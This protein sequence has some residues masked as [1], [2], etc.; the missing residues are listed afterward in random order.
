MNPFSRFLRQWNQDENVHQLMEHC[1]ALEALVVR[2]YRRDGATGADEAEYQAI[3]RWMSANYDRWQEQ[4]RP[5]WRKSMVGGRPLRKDPFMALYRH[6]SAASF[7]G[8]WEAMR[9]LPAVRE[10]LNQMLLEEGEDES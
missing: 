1:D 2:V 6:E 9:L 10:A 4:L 5:Y 7:V 8:D 3:R